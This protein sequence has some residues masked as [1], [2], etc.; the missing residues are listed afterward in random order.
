MK[1][2]IMKYIFILKLQLFYFLMTV[3]VTHTAHNKHLRALS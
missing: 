1:I 3:T 2:I